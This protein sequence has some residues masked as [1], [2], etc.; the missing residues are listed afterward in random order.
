[1]YSGINGG[2]DV[3]VLLG[4]VNLLLVDNKTANLYNDKVLKTQAII[5]VCF[6]KMPNTC[7]FPNY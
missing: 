4:T 7:A 6:C 3:E 1:M 2:S 5:Q